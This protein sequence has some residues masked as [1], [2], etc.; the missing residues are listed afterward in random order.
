MI[1]KKGT[2]LY[3]ILKL[4]CPKCHEGDLF[5]ESNA[6]NFKH[7]LDMPVRCPVCNQDFQIEPG[8]YSGAL[9]TSFPIVIIIILIFIFPLLSYP[10]YRVMIFVIMSGSMLFIQP[11]VMRWGR[12]IWINMFVHYDPNLKNKQ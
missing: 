1:L 2:N 5:V 10:E 7:T 4:K 9:W 12:A 8:F 6:W 3:S 11:I